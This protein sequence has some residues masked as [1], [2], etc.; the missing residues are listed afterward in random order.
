MNDE[1]EAAPAGA[2]ALHAVIELH[3]QLLCAGTELDRLQGLLSDAAQTLMHSFGEAD[4]L[5]RPMLAAGDADAAATAERARQVIET[6][7]SAAKALQF[8]DM[9]AQLIAFTQQ[10]VAHCA[11]RLA[12]SALGHDA[13]GEGVIQPA[14][15]RANPV[16]QYEMDTGLV[17]LF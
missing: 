7:G 9:A 17:E 6:L 15:G 2:V 5:L 8:Q 4:A 13:D 3:D 1:R 16:V 12:S 14:P 10:R 11:D